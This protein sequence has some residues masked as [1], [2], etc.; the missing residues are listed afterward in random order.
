MLTGVYVDV[1]KTCV[2]VDLSETP[3]ASYDPEDEVAL[4]ESSLLTTYWS[5]STLASR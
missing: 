2:Y 4:R 1:S 3:A 5:E